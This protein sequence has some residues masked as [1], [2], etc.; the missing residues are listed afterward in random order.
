MHKLIYSYL[1]FIRLP[2]LFISECVL[3]YISPIESSKL[4]SWIGET[5]DNPSFV[6]YEQIR[7]NDPFG[8]MMAKNLEDQGCPLLSLHEYPEL[9]SQINRFKNLNWQHAEAITMNDVYNKVLDQN[10]NKRYVY[11]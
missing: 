10:E 3:I 6:I 2:T 5:F 9:E 1:I 4:I 11:L 8:K 7:P